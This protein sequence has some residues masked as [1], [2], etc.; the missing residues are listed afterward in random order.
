MIVIRHRKIYVFPK[1][2]LLW[3]C[4][5][6]SHEICRHCHGVRLKRLSGVIWLHGEPVAYSELYICNLAVCFWIRQRSPANRIVCGQINL[7][8]IPQFGHIFDCNRIS[9]II[10][11]CVDQAVIHCPAWLN[12][13]VQPKRK[14]QAVAAGY[15]N[16]FF[17]HL[18]QI[19]IAVDF[20][21][22]HFIITGIRIVY[23]QIQNTAFVIVCKLYYM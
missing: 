2:H 21:F 9:A 15:L 8:E 3:L 18:F 19:A 6:I 16:I 4:A 5:V 1:L 7:F 17:Q 12:S 14:C 10:P 23:R 13:T 22:F 11:L 20:F